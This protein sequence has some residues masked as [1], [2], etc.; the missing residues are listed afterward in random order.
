MASSVEIRPERIE[1]AE[2]IR[3]VVESAFSGMPHADG[4]EPELVGA[5]R[6]QNALS[7]SLV[8]ELDGGIVGQVAFSPA[9]APGDAPGW[10]ALGPVAVLPAHQ[11]RGIG[12]ELVRVGL[13]MISDEGASGC[14]LTGNPA[15]YGRFGFVVSPESAPAG[16]PSEFFMVKL[17]RGE[18]PNGPI[19]FHEA[20][21]T[22]DRS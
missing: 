20:F 19:Q 6:A 18:L 13:R 17:L 12:S 11:R 15:Y 2:A 4:D 5:L 8:A 10:Y 22:R 7:L 1:D 14:I 16:E 9:R 3:R 21:D